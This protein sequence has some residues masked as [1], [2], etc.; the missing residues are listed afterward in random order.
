MAPVFPNVTS[1]E[2][3]AS[4]DSPSQM[5]NQ[6]ESTNALPL[7]MES[8]LPNM[9]QE[10]TPSL[11]FDTALL[12]ELQNIESMDLGMLD[13]SDCVS[14]NS[15]TDMSQQTQQAN[16]NCSNNSDNVMDVE[17]PDWL[18]VITNSNSLVS[19][20]NQQ[21]SCDFSSDPLLP[22]MGNSQEILDMFSLDDLDFKTSTDA[23][24]LSWD[25]V[26]FAT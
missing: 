25:K 5:E 7:K 4:S 8:E 21:K 19:T 22:S 1:T 12:L 6:Q 9:G 17:L 23:N 18:E 13:A 20:A 16:N 3:P 24:I 26:D 2:V 10:Q 14:Q 15:F 11:A